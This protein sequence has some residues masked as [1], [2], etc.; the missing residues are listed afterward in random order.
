MYVEVYT[1]LECESETVLYMPITP[2]YMQATYSKPFS[3]RAP[4]SSC[5]SH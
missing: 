2:D 5:I 1:Y 4:L 3:L